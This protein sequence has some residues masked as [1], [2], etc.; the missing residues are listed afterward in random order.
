MLAEALGDL[1]DRVDVAP[2]DVARA[3]DRLGRG[4]PDVR[5][6]APPGRGG[7]PGRRGAAL[8]D[9]GGTDAAFFRR[10][11]VPSYGAGMFSAEDAGEFQSRF[12][13]HDERIDTASLA[14]R[15]SCGSTSWTDPDRHAGAPRDPVRSRV[16]RRQD[17]GVRLGLG[18]LHTVIRPAGAAV[19]AVLLTGEAETVQQAVA[20][21]GAGGLA[22]S[23]HTAKATTRLAVNTSPE[24][25]SNAGVSLLEDGL[26]AT[27]IWFAVTN[28]V[29]ALVLVGVLVVAGTALTIALFAAARRGCGPGGPADAARRASR[30]G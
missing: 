21:L 18:P 10:R 27:V 24:P 20:A 14:C 17:P 25:I 5:P 2:G 3:G 9:V 26:V 1:A 7:P 6:A 13:G 30:R 12:H 11:G 29:V 15:R 19:L 4:H 22:L 23:A 16:R 8:D 28:P